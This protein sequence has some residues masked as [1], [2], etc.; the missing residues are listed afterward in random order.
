MRAIESG[1]SRIGKIK[2]ANV[3]LG[4]SILLLAGLGIS[5]ALVPLLTPLLKIPALSGAALSVVVKLPVVSRLIGHTMSD[6]LSATSV[7]VGLDQTLRIRERAQGLVSSLVGRIGVRTQGA[8]AALSGASPAP[9]R[10]SLGQDF[11]PVSEQERRILGTFRV[12]A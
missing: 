5:E 6:V 3:P 1:V 10:V 7:A 2:V 11:G 4:Q 9:A 12:P 8:R